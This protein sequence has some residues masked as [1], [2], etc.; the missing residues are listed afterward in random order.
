MI[1]MII[2]NRQ[3]IITILLLYI[4][5][6]RPFIQ[7]RIGNL[8]FIFTL[9][10]ALSLT[11]DKV[12]FINRIIIGIIFIF[13]VL[14]SLIIFEN[15]VVTI[16]IDILCSLILL[17][18]ISLIIESL[19]VSKTI[20]ESEIFGLLNCYIIIGIVFAFIYQLA[21]RIDPA[22]FDPSRIDRDSINSFIYFS[23][24]TI[25]TLGYG[26]IIPKSSLVQR[27]AIIEAIAGQFYIAIVVT[28]LLSRYIKRKGE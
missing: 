9:I 17:Y 18:C 4:L 12:K 2:K 21:F 28:Y 3:I 25:T 24:T 8:L 11:I 6:F 23:F 14:A 27:L 19:L 10:L 5:I 20:T 26:D 16:S 15:I 22:A 13:L 1:T 7:P